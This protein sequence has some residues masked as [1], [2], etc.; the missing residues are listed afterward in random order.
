[1]HFRLEDIKVNQ[2]DLSDYLKSH[3]STFDVNVGQGVKVGGDTYSLWW[4]ALQ[5]DQLQFDGAFPAGFFLTNDA[6]SQWCKDFNLSYLNL[7]AL[8]TVDGRIVAKTADCK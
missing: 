4:L 7:A 1:V 5:D 6:A 2:I 8:N 3:T